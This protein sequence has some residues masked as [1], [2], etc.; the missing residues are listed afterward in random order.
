MLDITTGSSVAP[1]LT[2]T[3]NVGV[4][5]PNPAHTVWFPRDKKL[6]GILFAILEPEAM[7]E[8]LDC[9]SSRLAWLVLESVFA[10]VSTS[11]VNQLGEALL[12]L[13]RESL[14]ILEYGKNFKTL[15]DQLS[16]IGKLIG[17]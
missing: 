8:V 4:E 7:V 12:S 13:Y 1:S 9:T 14:T 17:I 3:S 2:V 15:C 6:M 5:S 10:N 16:A 11:H